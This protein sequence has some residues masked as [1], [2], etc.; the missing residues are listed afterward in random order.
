MTTRY[1]MCFFRAVTFASHLTAW[2]ILYTALTDLG[3]PQTV[4]L[5]QL[6][7][8][9][10]ELIAC[11]RDRLEFLVFTKV[12]PHIS[13]HAY[14]AREGYHCLDRL[15]CLSQHKQH[16]Q[17]VVKE[18]LTFAEVNSGS[19]TPDRSAVRQDHRPPLSPLQC[20]ADGGIS[21]LM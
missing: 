16:L 14:T 12:G 9:R 18:V 10:R 8:L 6:D 15:T 3:M 2:L 21:P 11:A 17:D 13:A 19:S 7:S 1:E 4:A 20:S 5:S